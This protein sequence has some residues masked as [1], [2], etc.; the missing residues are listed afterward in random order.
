MNRSVAAT[1]NETADF[2]WSRLD[3]FPCEFHI[4]L[5]SLL[6]HLPAGSRVLDIGAGPGRYAIELVKAGH[7]VILGDLS[8]EMVSSARSR[9]AE[10]GLEIGAAG[11]GGIEDVLELD[12]RNLSRFE[13]ASFDA[14][15]ALGPFYHLQEAGD[16]QRA[17]AEVSRV[18]RPGGRLFAAFKPR[19]FWFSLALHTFVSESEVPDAYLEQLELLLQHGRLDKVRSPHL[20]NCWFCSPE[21]IEPL[22]AA[23]GIRHR[24]LLASSGVT[25]MWSRL[26]T[27]RAFEGRSVDLRRRLFELVRRTASDPNILGMSDQILFIGERNDT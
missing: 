19:T 22:F 7:R 18:L 6:E 3:R 25:A 12:A 21:D 14:V 9:L 2:Q 15:V 8:A 17:A 4:H 16:R 27:W 24:E 11:P 26:E 13:S 1:Y 10:E 5:N 20:K 23:V